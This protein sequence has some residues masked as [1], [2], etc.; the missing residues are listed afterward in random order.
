[1]GIEALRERAQTLGEKVTALERRLAILTTRS[2]RLQEQMS[3]TSRQIG[4]LEL[5]KH[6]LEAE[7]DTAE[8][9][10][11]ARA[12]EAYKQGPTT[13]I[14]LL[15]GT[16]TVSDFFTVLETQLRAAFN[17]ART[18]MDL[19]Q[20]QEAAQE[21]QD[22]IDAR[23]INLASAALTAKE[24]A[25]AS[26]ATVEERRSV[27]NEI[28]GQIQK[29][30]EQALLAAAESSQPSEALLRQLAPSGPA[31]DIPDGFVETDVTFEGI[32]SWYGPGFEGRHTA[33]GDVF[34][35]DL[36]T[37]ASRDLPLGTWLY[38]VH[39]GRGVVVLVN[40]RGPF[41][42]GRVLDL[43]QAAAEAIGI[44][45]L[46]WIEAEILIKT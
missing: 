46:G 45:G 8:S 5:A 6:D 34:D 7:I 14:E 12:V 25:A 1:M 4:I 24:L 22:A 19:V 11:A 27:L 30:E 23:Q 17:D 2:E 35:P 16:K 18:Y 37:A 20:A 21:Q 15:L 36:F 31:P 39:G 40:D 26:E 28:V 13:G 29:I 42:E 10:Y 32:A 9:R 33:S 43:S 3:A 44:T 38:V 41:I